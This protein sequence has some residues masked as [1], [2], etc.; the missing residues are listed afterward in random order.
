MTFARYISRAELQLISRNGTTIDRK[1]QTSPPKQSR[2]PIEPPPSPIAALPVEIVSRILK[3]VLKESFRVSVI[4]AN[5]IPGLRQFRAL[6]LTCKFFKAIVEADRLNLTIR[7]TAEHFD[8]HCFARFD[9]DPQIFVVEWDN[10]KPSDPNNSARKVGCCVAA[11]R[12][13]LAFELLQLLSVQHTPYDMVPKFGRF[14]SN[15]YIRLDDLPFLTKGLLH[16]L[17]PLLERTSRL[18]TKAERETMRLT[19]RLFH[20][21]DDIVSVI[22]GRRNEI[23]LYSVRRWSMGQILSSSS[24]ST[25][26]NEWWI[27]ESVGRCFGGTCAY[28][29]GYCKTGPLVVSL[30]NLKVSRMVEETK[31]AWR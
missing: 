8:H 13:H 14:L 10:S 30:N 9:A 15:P 5:P 29:V 16:R 2:E 24:I 7:C 27:F 3:I 4:K 31:P 22:M 11:E 18:P 19:A 6:I 1:R 21:R 23:L 12:W 20:S 26:V 25:R 17:G 28:V